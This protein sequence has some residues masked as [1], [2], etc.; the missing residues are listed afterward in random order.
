MQIKQIKESCLYVSEL[1]RSKNFYTTVLGFE[2]IGFV[3]G[4]HVFF[5]VGSSVLLC[6]LNAATMHDEHLPAHDGNGHLHIAFEVEKCDYEAFKEMLVN[7]NIVIE[8][9][10]SWPGGF[11][12]FYFRDPD[13]HLL[14]IVQPGMWD[15]H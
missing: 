8:H 1:E 14:E 11:L 9:E 3:P 12:S 5:K 15:Q 13:G 2:M 4:R 10:H 6:F 7:K